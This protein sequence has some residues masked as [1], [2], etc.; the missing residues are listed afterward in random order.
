MQQLLVDEVLSLLLLL[1]RSV[2]SGV[3]GTF[4]AWRSSCHRKADAGAE[5]PIVTLAVDTVWGILKNKLRQPNVP[6]RLFDVWT[7]EDA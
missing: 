3:I 1:A 6:I 7:V 5:A 4:S 2:A